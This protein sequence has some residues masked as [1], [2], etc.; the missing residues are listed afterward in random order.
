MQTNL[1]LSNPSVK[2]LTKELNDMKLQMKDYECEL[3]IKQK[4]IEKLESINKILL[5][6]KQV[7]NYNIKN[8]INSNN[9]TG[10]YSYVAENFKNAPPLRKLDNF[11]IGG[12]DPDKEDEIDKFTEN[13]IHYK[14]N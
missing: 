6:Q 1:Q 8:N 7:T 10:I 9:N 2:N 12:F 13:I 14:K 3:K 11:V 4:E 5:E